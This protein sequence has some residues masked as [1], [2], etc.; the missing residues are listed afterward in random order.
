LMMEVEGLYRGPA[1]LI[2]LETWVGVK[3]CVF[4]RSSGENSTTTLL[5]AG[6]D[7]PR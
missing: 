6:C 5:D 1:S 3:E 7:S 2:S 4:E